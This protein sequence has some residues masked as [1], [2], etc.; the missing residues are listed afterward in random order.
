MNRSAS[1][2]GSGVEQEKKGSIILEVAGSKAQSWR[3]F[4]LMGG[5]WGGAWR[6]K[7]PPFKSDF[8]LTVHKYIPA[9]D[10]CRGTDSEYYLCILPTAPV[11]LGRWA[12]VWVHAGI[13]LRSEAT[14]PRPASSLFPGTFGLSPPAP[15]APSVEI[16]KEPHPMS[17]QSALPPRF[18][19]QL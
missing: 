1:E 12:I 17:L 6:L 18:H 9:S 2:D 19:R 16:A 5:Q 3:I 15:P 13:A 4:G 14:S 11:N 7:L 10:T 8:I